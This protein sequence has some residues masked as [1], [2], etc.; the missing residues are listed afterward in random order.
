LGWTPIRIRPTVEIL[1]KLEKTRKIKEL[2]SSLVQLK[3]KFG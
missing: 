3:S 1:E 2:E